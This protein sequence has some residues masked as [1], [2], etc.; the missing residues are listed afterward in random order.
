[1]A[2]K[3][4]EFTCLVRDMREAQK[5]YFDTRDKAYLKKA[6][7]IEKRWMT[8]CKRLSGGSKTASRHHRG[9][10]SDVHASNSPPR[11][12]MADTD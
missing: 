8:N 1:M 3:I 11:A 10:C 9:G 7:E 4:S 5:L 6:R 12:D 2:E